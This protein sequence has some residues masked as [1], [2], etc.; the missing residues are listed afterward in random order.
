MLLNCG[1]GKKFE[2]PLDCKEIQPVNKGNQSWMFIGRTETETETTILWPPDVKDWLI[3]K[4]PDPRKDQRREKKGETEDEMVGWHY[5]HDGHEFE[6]APGVGDGQRSLGMLQSMGSQK[7]RQDWVTEL[8]EILTYLI[9]IIF[10]P[11]SMDRTQGVSELLKAGKILMGWTCVYFVSG[12]REIGL[13]CILDQNLKWI[14]TNQKQKITAVFYPILL[15]GCFL[16][17][18]FPPTFLVQFLVH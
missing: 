18:Y 14:L 4:D 6:Q 16:F 1:V 13:L 12:G 9:P 10:Q 15:V 2:S 11:N 7:L 17:L 8:N 3:G 5:R